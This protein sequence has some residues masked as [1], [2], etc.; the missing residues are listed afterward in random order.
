MNLNRYPNLF[1]PLEAGPL[2]FRNRI[3]IAPV[4][5]PIIMDNNLLDAEAMFDEIDYK[6]SGG[7][8][9]FI[10]GE[11]DISSAGSRGSHP[12]CDFYDLS[13]ENTGPFRRVADRVHSHGCKALLEL[14]HT[15]D[16]KAELDEENPALG[17]VERINEAGVPVRAMTKADIE[18]CC[19]DFAQAAYFLKVCGFDG[20]LLHAGHGWLLS[21][22]LS[23]RTNRRADEYGGSLPN[24]ARITVEALRAI[25]G[26]C[27]P[28]FFIECR[29]SGSERAEGGY[30]LGD[31]CGYSKIISAYCDMIHVSSGLYRDPMRTLMISTLYKP[32][33]CNADIAF[34]IKKAVDIP[35]SV[36]GGINSPELAERLIAEGK[37]DMVALGRQMRADAQWGVKAGEGRSDGIR[38]CIRC[39]RCYPGPIEEVSAEIGAEGK[40]IKDIGEILD[41]LGACTVNPLYKYKDLANAPKAETSKKV[42]VIGGGAAGLQ[43]AITAAERGHEV[44]LAEKAEKVGGILNY[45][46]ET[47]DKEDLYM[48]ARALES[49]ARGLGVD[50]RTNTPFSP[51]LLDELKPGAAICA[52]GSSPSV[53]QIPGIEGEN[54]VQAMQA[55]KKGFCEG[56]GQKIVVLGGGLVGCETAVHLCKHGKTVTLLEML[57]GLARDAYRLHRQQLIDLMD[58]GVDYRLN[59]RVTAI[60][61]EGVRAAG[62]DGEEMF[63]P[64]DTVINALGMKA[65]PTAGIEA[66]VKAIG[67]DYTAVGDCVSARTLFEAVEEGFTAAM[68]L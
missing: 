58:D 1:S 24:R 44:I 17:P 8:A 36:V 51:A 31:I 37:C 28:G 9:E 62:K 55:Y 27:G 6:A 57:P 19:G 52:A 32:H 48:F 63:F 11:A 49:I 41:L 39:M 20:A 68:V 23:P 4:S 2:T 13:D 21:S 38:R 60:T 64:A 18:Q 54:V 45:A 53:P 56:A 30:S 67:A 29:V 5:G 3:A 35:V 33:G 7:A 15:G 16:A 10:I 43:A 47:D 12:R 59:A 50:I 46:A 22:F 26:K 40:N 42:L 25:R 65:N 34:E 14:A 66:A 61:P